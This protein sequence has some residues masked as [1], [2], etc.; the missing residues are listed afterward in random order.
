MTDAK[1]RIGAAISIRVILLRAVS[2]GEAAG[3]EEPKVRG[4]G[5]GSG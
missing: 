1:A 4:D 3:S 2:S 5:T